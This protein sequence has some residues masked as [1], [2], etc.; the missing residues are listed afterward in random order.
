MI[1][2]KSPLS[3]ELVYNM[4]FCPEVTASNDG[5]RSFVSCFMVFYAK[6]RLKPNII[7]LP[8]LY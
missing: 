5:L 7:D 3:G 1:C 8:N 4:T 2:N 6:G